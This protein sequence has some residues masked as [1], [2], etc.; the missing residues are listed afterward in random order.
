MDQSK[1]KIVA[2]QDIYINDCGMPCT[3]AIPSKLLKR[4]AVTLGVV[5]KSCSSV[6]EKMSP[7]TRLIR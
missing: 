4:F 1:R 7:I 3:Y 2:A 5:S 6:R